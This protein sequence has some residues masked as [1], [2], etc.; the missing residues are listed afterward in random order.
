MAR[1]NDTSVEAVKAAADMVDVVSA[2]TPLRK[3]GARFT[4]RCPF[5]EER[6]PSFSVNAV[7]K[8]YYCFGCGAGGDLIKFVRETENLDFAGAVEWLGERFR[9]PLEYDEES[10]QAEQRQRHRRRLLELL[11]QAASFYERY[12]WDAGGAEAARGYLAGRGLQ[13]EVLHEFRIGYAPGGQTLVAKAREKGFTG[14]ELAAAGLANRRSNDYFSGRIVFPLADARGRV[15][16]FQ[17]RRLREDDPIQAKYVN[18]PEGELFQKGAILYGLDL[19]RAAIAKA[20]QAIVVEGN[21]DVI[22][23]RQAGIQTVV[24]SM[25][26]ALTE[27]QLKELSRLTRH[28]SL[29]FDGDAAGEAATLRGMELAVRQGLAV[30]VVSLP[31]G[32]DPAD[33]GAEFTAW[34]EQ[35]KSYL[36]HR[37]QIEIARAPDRH[38][39]FVRLREVL[40]PFEDSPDRQDAVR[41]AA[42]RLGLPP[43]TQAG[44]APRTGART[45]TISPKL[46]DA[47]A[48]RE[49]EALAGVLVYP[50]LRSLLA[51]L[52]P[53]NFESEPLRRLRDVIVLEGE[54]PEELLPLWAELQA[55]ADS[56]EIGEATAK[57]LLLR[58]RERRLARELAANPERQDLA[59]QLGRVRAA[60]DELL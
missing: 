27:Q 57:E 24:A 50:K 16:G 32:S 59:A 14:E 47:D 9:V 25:G 31:P 45:G 19:A 30:K 51:E 22:A 5:H 53:D 8:L 55:R 11:D 21:T 42:D 2:R 49:K 3:A 60:I 35:G 6:T 46:L 39:A 12:L 52:A 40:A 7:D 1:I 54:P 26:T 20:E 43:E 13:E 10:P 56:D 4:G 34:L 15:L 17:A 23:L 29:C 44:L 33:L 18:S 58:L 37:V 38:E 28:V 48:R 36:L 41:Y